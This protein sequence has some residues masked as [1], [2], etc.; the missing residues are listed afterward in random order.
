MVITRFMTAKAAQAHAADKYIFM[1]GE[2][3]FVSV[4][5]FLSRPAQSRRY[6][7]S[8]ARYPTI[9][10]Q[11]TKRSSRWRPASSFVPIRGY[12][13]AWRMMSVGRQVDSKLANISEAS[14]LKSAGLVISLRED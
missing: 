7:F 10:N 12:I 5:P 14:M 3:E 2:G 6:F 8:V 4:K 9:V 1:D 11:C 13:S